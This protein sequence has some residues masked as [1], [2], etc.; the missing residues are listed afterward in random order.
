[1]LGYPRRVLFSNDDLA[2]NIKS[3]AGAGLNINDA[4]NILLG[5]FN[6]DGG[7]GIDGLYQSNLLDTALSLQ[8]LIT[9]NYLDQNIFNSAV[10]YLISAQNTDGGWGFYQGD[11]S[12]I[13][14]TALVSITMQQFS[15]TAMLSTSISKATGYLTA[16]QN[17]DGG[18]GSPSTVYETSYAYMALV[19]LITD[20][21]ILNNAVTYITSTQSSD[22]SWNEDPYSTALALRA[23]YLSA[24]T[25]PPTPSTTGIVA[26]AV[27]DATTNQ[28]LAGVLVFLAA[29]S[30]INTVT[31][32]SG[33]FSL[34]NVPAGGQRL[35]FSLNGYAQAS[36]DFTISAGSIVSLGNI[37]LSASSTTGIIKGLVTD[38]STG[39]PISGV[40]IT[41][42]GSY[43][44]TVTTGAD[45][46]FVF[47]NVPP[48]STTISASK[49]GYYTVS[50]TGVVVAGG[51][52]FFNLQL[53]TAPPGATTGALSGKVYD[54]ITKKPI[55][56]ASVVI[57][58][59]SNVITDANGAFWID[60]ISPNTYQ[61]TVSDVGYASQ[62]Y[63]TNVN[64]G[65]NTDLGVVLLLPVPLSTTVTG[66]ITDALT[67][68]PI[69][70][71]AVS[72]KGTAITTNTAADGS[73][74]V[75]GINLLQF[76]LLTTAVGYSGQ[77]S[78]VTTQSYGSFTVNMALGQSSSPSTLIT[79]N[80]TVTPA[81][82]IPDGDK[83]INMSIQLKGMG[84]TPTVL[85]A[86]K[87]QA[88]N[89]VTIAFDR[90]M[91]D[92]SGMQTQ[93]NMI[94]GSAN[95]TVTAA[96]LNSADPSK[97]DLTL[98]QPITVTDSVW[99]SYVAGNI[100]SAAGETLMS[101][102][103]IPVDNSASSLASTF[104]AVADY[105]ASQNP[106]GT[107]SYGWSTT[108]VSPLIVYPQSSL[109]Y[110]YNEI[111][112]WDDPGNLSLGAPCVAKNMTGNVVSRGTVSWQ[113]YQLSFHPG[114]TGNFSHIRWTAPRSGTVSV[115]AGFIGIDV[116]GT[117]TDVHV[118]YNG[119]AIFNDVINRYGDSRSFLTN[120]SVV[121]GD[122]IDFAVGYGTD[123]TFNFDSTGLSATITYL[124]QSIGNVRVIDTIPSAGIVIDQ[125]SFNKTPSSITTDAQNTIVEW[126]YDTFA[127][128]QVENLTFNATMVNPVGGEQRLVNRTLNVSYSD[129]NDNTG[130]TQ[131]GA[132]Y[133]NVMQSAFQTVVA[134]D[135][136][137]YGANSNVTITGSITNIGNYTRTIDASILIEDSQGNLVTSVT[138]VP[139]LVIPAG[140]Q[141]SIGTWI[142]NTG[143]SLA[144]AYRAH[145]ILYDRQTQVG[146]AIANFTIQPA[147]TLTSNVSPDKMA[148]NSNEQV[149]NGT[150]S[151][152]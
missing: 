63:Q 93:F 15:Q 134:T 17:S 22:G 35:Q 61:V 114:Q 83:T 33:V 132:Y 8:A 118:V 60:N 2:H 135:Q 4:E 91:A 16:N 106:T 30:T 21:T 85:Y 137:N 109:F 53:S 55:Q 78:S 26:G 76:Q 45:G 148:Y 32:S 47:T 117:T 79:L 124:S 5:G 51:M 24:N 43:S 140:G 151:K 92:P 143:S 50:G 138:T 52:Q 3:L 136:S 9:S 103:D 41:A 126:D 113:P 28:P 105:S 102:N 150:S 129:S 20:N 34:T 72:V 71:A 6:S 12:N 152:Y 44:G 99:L 27:I 120:L 149:H 36:A 19:G 101:F 110:G 75:T 131:L 11:D 74:T 123:D 66:K 104:D 86:I 64:A 80:K 7:W 146:E 142:F 90:P 127:I 31:D 82:V 122:I 57:A 39:L 37:P 115:T 1:M 59:G 144:G 125:T 88:G 56:G 46:T 89:I 128:G 116:V 130:G 67:G 62:P 81:S 139:S 141:Q 119:T 133:V 96:A 48:G 40:A 42:T 111:S 108:L 107:W 10:N 94:S 112:S 54:A 70:F 58:G 13:Y 87:N 95:W 73:Y 145:L 84:T 18:F 29:N 65:A 68:H 97:I 147:M 23:L 14:I 77:T 69:S 100:Q 49:N 25:M 38:S 98:Q 121:A